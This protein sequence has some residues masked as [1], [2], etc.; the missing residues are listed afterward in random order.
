MMPAFC[1]GVVS[2]C[3][4]FLR[5]EDQARR[6]ILFRKQPTLLGVVAITVHLAGIGARGF[7]RLEIEDDE[8]A[9]PAMEEEQVNPIPSVANAQGPF[10]LPACAPS[11]FVLCFM[12]ER[13]SQ[14]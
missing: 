2:S 13:R 3:G 10:T 12:T 4:K 7:I 11:S 14:H 9:Q 8:T 1:Q 5:A 6:G